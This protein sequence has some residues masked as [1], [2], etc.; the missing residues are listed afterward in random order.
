M[1][2]TY[3]TWRRRRSATEMPTAQL[4]ECGIDEW[5][6]VDTATAVRAALAALPPRQRAVIVLRYL[7]DLTETQ[8]ADALGCSVGTVKSQTSK[9]LARLRA[10]NLLSEEDVR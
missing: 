1:V 10:A 2:R 5:D 6:A 3:L 7:D 9:A 8:A 4:P